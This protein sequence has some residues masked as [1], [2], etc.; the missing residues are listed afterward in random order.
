MILRLGQWGLLIAGVAI[1][2]ASAV[3]PFGVLGFRCFSAGSSCP[4][5]ADGISWRLL[6]E[7]II[8][9]AQGAVLAVVLAIPGAHVFSR[10][11][12]RFR[13]T[14]ASVLILAPVLFPPMV[15]AFG[16]QRL[17]VI[18]DSLRCVLVWASWAWPVPAMLIGAVWMRQGRRIYEEAIMETSSTRAILFA[19]LPAIW[20]P[21]VISG[22]VLFAFFLGDYSVPHACGLIVYA[23]DLLSRA[24]SSGN[25]AVA[26]YASIP[27][28]VVIAL[29]MGLVFYLWRYKEQ[30]TPH[31]DDCLGG[32]VSRRLILP[33][34][35]VAGGVVLPVVSLGRKIPLVESMKSTIE[36]YGSSVAWSL[37]VSLLA[38]LITVLMAACLTTF[39]RLRTCSL[40]WSLMLAAFPGALVGAAIVSA[41]YPYSFIYDHWPVMV[42]AYIGRYGWIGVLVCY[43]AHVT[44]PDE[45]VQAAKSDGAGRLSCTWRVVLALNWPL[46]A[47]GVLVIAALNLSEVAAT[48]LVRVPSIN[49]VSLVLIE[50]FHRFEDGIMISLCM[51][52]VAATIPGAILAGVAGRRFR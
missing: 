42:L 12:H 7:S 8:L 44:C 3:Y 41:Y 30:G 18:P 37:T 36:L 19:V 38:G 25:P 48:S 28:C 45:L 50:K 35:M 10:L 47:G 14:V 22:L 27:I 23:T 39:R 4:A 11:G 15:Y 33:M 16:W 46:L 51:L 32:N 34:L 43:L 24:E 13:D 31:Q 26:A 9:A 49:P 2:A 17:V 5:V 40:V 1:F 21:L 29:T 52:L 20:R 6:T